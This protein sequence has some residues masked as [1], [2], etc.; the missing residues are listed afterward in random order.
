[1]EGLQL[2]SFIYGGIELKY[3]FTTVLKGGGEF[4]DNDG[5]IYELTGIYLPT[6]PSGKHFSV[7]SKD[8][9]GTEEWRGYDDGKVLSFSCTDVIHW[10]S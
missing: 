1:M 10:E 8:S 7:T 3:A 4:Q 2:A 5:E 6:S 9:E